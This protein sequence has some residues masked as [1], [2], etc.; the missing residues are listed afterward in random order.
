MYG[1]AAVF[2]HSLLK[3]AGYMVE[4]TCEDNTAM[5]EALDVPD[6]TNIRKNEIIPARLVDFSPIR[7]TFLSSHY[8]GSSPNTSTLPY[9]CPALSSSSNRYPAEINLR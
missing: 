6:R 5:P 2:I 3:G 9:K 1:K 7:V 8:N 4:S